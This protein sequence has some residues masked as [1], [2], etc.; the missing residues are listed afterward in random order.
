[1]L[2]ACTLSVCAATPEEEAA[3]RIANLEKIL[4]SVPGSCG[5]AE[6]DAYAASAGAS[7]TLAVT[8]SLLLKAALE[9]DLSQVVTLAANL[10]NEQDAVK[11]NAELAPKAAEALKKISPLKAGK[12][13]KALDFANKCSQIV[14]EE[15]IYQA[16]KI[17]SLAK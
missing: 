2:F 4:K 3:T 13:K 9:G 8:N 5:V 10:K 7:G 11:K 16:E 12:A 14:S 15:T 17:A 6:I 1:M